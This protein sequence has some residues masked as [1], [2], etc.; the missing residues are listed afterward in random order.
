MCANMFTVTL[1]ILGTGSYSRPIS[2]DI[3]SIACID[4]LTVAKPNIKKIN[5]GDNKILVI[6]TKY[7]TQKNV[8]KKPS[9]NLDRVIRCE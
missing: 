9:Q 4:A 3:H 5:L 8:L 1:C 7:L 2:S 6:G